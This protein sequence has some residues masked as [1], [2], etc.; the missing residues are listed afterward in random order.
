MDELLTA[1]RDLIK[2][3]EYDGTGSCFL[4]VFS[5]GDWHWGGTDP[6]F[7][8]LIYRLKMYTKKTSGGSNGKKN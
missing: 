1:V 7:N 5:R 3:V 2:Y 4:K 8:D 6:Q